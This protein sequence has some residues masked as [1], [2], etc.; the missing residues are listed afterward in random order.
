MWTFLYRFG[1]P[2]VFYQVVERTHFWLFF[3]ALF[4]IIL[5]WLWGFGFSPQDYQQGDSVRIMYIHVPSA[6]LSLFIYGMMATAS[7]LTMVWQ[8][9]IAALM[10]KACAEVGAVMTLLALVTGSVWGKPTWGTW[11]VWDARLTGEL[12]LLFIYFSLLAIEHSLGRNK[13]SD[14]IFAM[15]CWI[16]LLD[17]PIIH[18]SVQWWNTLHQGSSL[19]TFA[20]PKIHLS[21][22]YPLLFS[23]IGMLLFSL[24]SIL[25][26]TQL[27]LLKREF[28]QQW[29]KELVIK[30]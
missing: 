25:K 5:G 11:W 10:Q 13:A 22:L 23:L 8:I 15:L 26:L 19:L 14:K 9:K 4:C 30:S 16:G 3:I 6:F 12:V 20:K 1:T 28:K 17:L 21:M 24:W 29:V 27:A 18:Y 7:L 2:K